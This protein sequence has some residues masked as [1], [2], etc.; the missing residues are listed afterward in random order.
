[1]S[2]DQ[3]CLLSV[4]LMIHALGLQVI[5]KVNELVGQAQELH[6]PGEAATTVQ[7]CAEK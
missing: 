4:H 2:A 1:M 5:P 6:V 7:F 3:V